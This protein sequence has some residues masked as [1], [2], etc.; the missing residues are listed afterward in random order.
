MTA[1]R[2]AT[3]SLLGKRFCLATKT[4]VV[5]ATV[6]EKLL[7]TTQPPG[8][9]AGNAWCLARDHFDRTILYAGYLD[10]GIIRS[11]D[12]GDTWEICAPQE[13]K[14]EE[15][16]SLASSPW[17]SRA[18]YAGTS[19]PR[20]FRSEDSG[21]SWEEIG[22]IRNVP[23]AEH[24]SFPEPPHVAHI[25]SFAF[26]PKVK[27]VLYVGVEEGGVLRTRDEK[28]WEALNEGLYEDIH[29]LLPSPQESD[30]LYVTTGA[31]FYLSENAGL[32]WEF[33]ETG[34]RSYVVP[35][36]VHPGD[37]EVLLTAGAA[38]PPPGWAGRK[39]ASAFV[40]KSTD[41]GKTWEAAKGDLFPLRSMVMALA[42]DPSDPDRVYGGST[43][44]EILISEDG[45]SGWELLGT[46]KEGIRSILPI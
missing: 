35:L 40:F 25:R 23:G 24:W 13:A 45:G 26:D 34:D 44:G 36:A 1:L 7:E 10:H 31:G 30:R 37:Q 46:T 29:T 21:Q 9:P 12:G 8:A 14:G 42:F 33:I 11:L 3:V 32:S 43:H 20:L 39:G 5:L 38:T 6:R 2:G 27:E 19:G 28:T 4:G 18:I 16:W 15:I 22:G 17:K 41:R